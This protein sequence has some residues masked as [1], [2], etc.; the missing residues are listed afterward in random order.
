MPD[1]PDIFTGGWVRR[2]ISLDG[3]PFHED[4]IVWWLQGPRLHADLRVA[5]SGGPS[6]CFAGVTT[7]DGEALTW[8]RTIDL[9]HYAGID[10]GTATWDG[11]DLLESGQFDNDDGTVTTYVERWVRLP[12]SSEP[13]WSQVQDDVYAVRAGAYALTICDRRPRGGSFLGTAW[14]LTSGRWTV[15]HSLPV[16]ELAVSP[17]DVWAQR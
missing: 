9:E 14:E 2:G 8:T 16:P 7:W 12:G 4:S 13:L 5:I 10:T 3:R 11:E 1:I 15:H 17:S 6:T